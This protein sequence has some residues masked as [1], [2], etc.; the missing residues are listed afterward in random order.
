M[1]NGSDDRCKRIDVLDSGGKV[2]TAEMR[3]IKT[4]PYRCY[5]T[6]IFIFYLTQN[7]KIHVLTTQLHKTIK[8]ITKKGKKEKTTDF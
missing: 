3:A 1:T 2:R 5:L 7:T 6:V 4:A 8:L